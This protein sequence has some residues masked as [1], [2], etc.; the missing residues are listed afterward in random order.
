MKAAFEKQQVRFRPGDMEDGIYFRAKKELSGSGYRRSPKSVTGVQAYLIV[1]TPFVH[2]SVTEI[3][4]KPVHVDALLTD[5]RRQ[6]YNDGKRS[7][8]TSG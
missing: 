4:R 5:E 2:C 7:T 1:G 3:K 6:L 8:A